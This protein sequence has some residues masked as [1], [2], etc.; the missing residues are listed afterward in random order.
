MGPI[1]QRGSTRPRFVGTLGAAASPRGLRG[2]AGLV[3][4]GL[5]RAVCLSVRLLGAPSPSPGPPALG[6]AGAVG[7]S[8]RS[9]CPP[10]AL[11]GW[12]RGRGTLRQAPAVVIPVHRSVFSLPRA[13]L[14]GMICPSLFSLRLCEL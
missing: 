12:G 3:S 1:L 5:G 13:F 8:A 10:L 7:L 2:E 11:R 6:A 14:L 4:V 9:V